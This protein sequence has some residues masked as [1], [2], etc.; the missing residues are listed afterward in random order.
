MTPER[1]QSEFKDALQAMVKGRKSCKSKEKAVDKAR[2]KAEHKAALA[3][4]AA[5]KEKKAALW[6][7]S[8]S[9][10]VKVQKDERLQTQTR[11]SLKKRRRRRRDSIS[12]YNPSPKV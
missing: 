3:F 6:P 12:E 11:R 4:E 5:E 1:D 9:T 10:P 8:T 2:A 7:A